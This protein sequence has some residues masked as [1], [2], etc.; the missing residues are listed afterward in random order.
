MRLG[1]PLEQGAARPARFAHAPAA[2]AALN[3]RLLYNLHHLRFRSAWPQGLGRGVP[4][5]SGPQ[6]VLS[7]TLPGF[8]R[9]MNFTDKDRRI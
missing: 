7:G 2:R 5:R 3:T 9:H 4:D 8:I 6:P 1:T